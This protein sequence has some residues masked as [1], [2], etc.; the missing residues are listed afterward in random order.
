MGPGTPRR[1]GQRLPRGVWRP[2]YPMTHATDAPNGTKTVLLIPFPCGGLTMQLT[3]ETDCAIRIM[4]EVAGRPSG[5]PTTTLEISRRR[6][7]P[8]PFLRKIVS[9]LVGAGLIRSRRGTNGGLMLA[10]PSEEIDLL[11]IIEAVQGPIAVNRCVL[12]PD[13]CPLRPTCP[14]HEVCQIARNQFIELMRGVTLADLVRRG[15]ELRARP[16]RAV[17]PDRLPQAAPA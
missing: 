12:Q 4:L 2:V 1:G 6:L 14:V 5:V 11:S 10:R 7:A 17:Q 9:R 16:Q 15:S 3:Q 13:I 8:R